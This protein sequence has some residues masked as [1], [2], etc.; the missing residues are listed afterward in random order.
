M[1]SS[2]SLIDRIRSWFED[3]P[4]AQRAYQ[5][6]S[7]DL[8]A[9]VK[10]VDSSTSGLRERVTPIIDPARASAVQDKASEMASAVRDKASEV[11]SAVQDKAGETASAVQDKAGETASAVQDKA[12][13][14]ESKVEPR[15]PNRQ[16]DRPAP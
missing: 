7:A 2:N 8:D 5:R 16:P 13:E 11:A 4:K 10:W 9:V 12:G 14:T 3:S 1:D 15:A 6:L